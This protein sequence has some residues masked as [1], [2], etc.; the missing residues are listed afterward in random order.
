MKR[1]LLGSSLLLTWLVETAKAAPKSCEFH[2][3]REQEIDIDDC[4]HAKKIV[5]ELE[6]GHSIEFESQR[7][8]KKK[9]KKEPEQRRRQ[10]KTK[11][12]NSKVSLGLFDTTPPTGTGTG[13]LTGTSTS[14]S[15]GKPTPLDEDVNGYQYWYGVEQLTGSYL[16]IGFFDRGGIEGTVTDLQ[17]ATITSFSIKGDGRLSFATTNAEDFLPEDHLSGDHLLPSQS[18]SQSSGIRSRALDTTTSTTTSAIQE[19][20]LQQVVVIGVMVVWTK[21]AECKK[22]GRSKDC[23]RDAASET[24]MRNMIDQMVEDTNTAFAESGVNGQILLVHAYCAVQYNDPDK[25]LDALEDLQQNNDKLKDADGVRMLVNR[26]S[27]GA[28]LVNIVANANDY[29]GIAYTSTGAHIGYSMVHWSCTVGNKSFAHELGHNLVS[30]RYY[31]KMNLNILHLMFGSGNPALTK[32]TSPSTSRYSLVVTTVPPRTNAEH[33][34]VLIMDIE[35]Q[36]PILG[37]FNPIVVLIQVVLV[38]KRAVV[39]GSYDMPMMVPSII[40]II[41]PPALPTTSAPN[42]FQIPYRPLPIILMFLWCYPTLILINQA[43]HLPRV[44][45]QHRRTEN[46]PLHPVLLRRCDH[47]LNQLQCRRYRS[48]LR[49]LH[50]TALPWNP[51]R[52]HHKCRL[53]LR[54]SRANPVPNQASFRLRNLPHRRRSLPRMPLVMPKSN[55]IVDIP[56]PTMGKPLPKTFLPSVS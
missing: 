12:K 18:Q 27:Y 33:Q 9:S 52:S 31:N 30:P 21:E 6:D 55:T 53:R 38:Q 5:V 10:L 44:Q 4:V 46:L 37:Q 35:I 45:V 43:K 54:H 23:N 51:Q 39:E 11:K 42:P 14:T 8:N 48:S 40:T 56:H 47:L 28:D 41:N 24:I 36:M 26:E 25:A 13:T 16:S 7:Q 34:M 49:V 1:I 20:E 22:A 17:D 32:T 29:C 50:P 3:H 15:T 2:L 19:R